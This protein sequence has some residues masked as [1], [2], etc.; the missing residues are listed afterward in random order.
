VEPVKVGLI[1]CG[2][3]SA[4][5]LEAARTFEILDFVAC[6]DLDPLAAKATAEAFGI[7]AMSVERLLESEAEVV[8]NLTIPAAHGEVN[9]AALQAGKHAYCEKPFALD[10]ADGKRVLELAESRGLRIGCAPDTFLGGGFQTVR[11]LVDEGA[12]GRPVAG[13]AFMMN[14]G[15][16][17]WHPNPGFYYKR[18]GGPLFDMGP[19]Y[20]TALVNTLGAV[21]RVA[22]LTSRGFEQRT[23]TSQPRTGERVDVEVDTHTAG[24]LEFVDGAIVSVVM[25]FD[26]WL[27][28]SRFIEIHGTESS[29]SAPDP[30]GFDGLC[31]HFDR[32]ARMECATDHPRLYREYAQHR[33]CGYVCGHQERA[34][35]P[36]L[37]R[38]KQ[39]IYSHFIG[40]LW[41]QPT[42]QPTSQYLSLDGL[43]FGHGAIWGPAVGSYIVRSDRIPKIGELMRDVMTLKDFA[44]IQAAQRA[45][46]YNRVGGCPTA[47]SHAP[48]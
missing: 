23:I 46:A 38:H 34:S 4:A 22:A 41:L 5:Y 36:P 10:V 28:S 17:G 39:L 18:G 42:V 31:G 1:G 6:A 7:E 2:V 14:H 35:A 24:T 3:I 25:S 40:E 45:V 19:Y 30:N 8:L 37:F 47:A 13:T 21:K 29:L 43:R 16:E 32:R 44:G 48:Q 15:P 20:L 33:P 9:R 26:T 11:K 27:H 12:I